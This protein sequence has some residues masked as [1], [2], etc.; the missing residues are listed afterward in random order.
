MVKDTKK[1]NNT[2]SKVKKNNREVIKNSK[3][4]FK[5]FLFSKK[6]SLFDLLFFIII[7]SLASIIITSKYI[8][9]NYK[10]R[11]VLCTSNLSKDKNLNEFNSIYQE[12]V[13]NYYEEVDKKG[14]INAAVDGM[15]GY[16]EDT[17]SIHM[18]NNESIS[19]D[20]NL[21]GS[22]QGIGIMIQVNEILEVYDD[23]PASK[24]GLKKGDIIKEIAGDK[25]T[26]DNYFEVI[27]KIK[28]N[29]ESKI[30]LVIERDGKTIE[31]EI[32]V[33]KVN[34]PIVT[35]NFVSI[36]NKRIGYI[37]INSFTNNSFEQFSEQLI[38]LEEKDHIENL[39]IDVRNNGGGYLEQAV[40][41]ASLFVKK[42]NII[43][44]LQ[45]KKE[46]K[47]IKDTT[48]DNR[49]YKIIVLVNGSSASAS[50]ILALSL[51]DNNGA[52]LVGEKTYGKGKVQT[53]KKL[54]DGTT[55]KYTSSKWLGPVGEY[56]DG[57]GIT[58]DYKV[59]QK[60]NKD[61]QYE[62]AISLLK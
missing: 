48:K 15:L 20:D 41:I 24:A 18:D 11:G 60:E 61:N 8:V 7:V 58:P 6:H 49:N 56:I 35:S 62:K 16:L 21:E 53:T 57:E 22:Y 37:K 28:K 25:L 38:K 51:K 12:V 55:L 40:D 10:N 59:E 44:S 42:G 4:G 2:V 54:E 34:L 45:D 47:E 17:Y 50:E 30:K 39:I 27:Q 46:T 43:Y 14:M 23:S 52:I 5:E 26:E 32:D 19:F 31:K 1:K 33:K 29:L 9:H 3:G 36:N 13:D